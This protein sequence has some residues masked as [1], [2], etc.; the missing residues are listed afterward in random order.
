LKYVFYL[1][2]TLYAAYNVLWFIGMTF[3]WGPND[4]RWEAIYF[5]L[6]FIADVPVVWWIKRSPRNGCIAL[7]ILLIAGIRLAVVEGIFNSFSIRYW[8]A[9]K[10]IIAALGVWT[11]RLE[12]KSKSLRS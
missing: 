4:P 12:M 1:A 11:S 8:Y 6:T 7:F 5:S 2:L 10:L 9:P 3:S